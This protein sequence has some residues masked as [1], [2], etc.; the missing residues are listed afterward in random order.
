MKTNLK[1]VSFWYVRLPMGLAMFILMFIAVNPTV[2]DGC[3]W[4]G[5]HPINPADDKL[6]CRAYGGKVNGHWVGE[7]NV[8]GQIFIWESLM[9]SI[10]GRYTALTAEELGRPAIESWT[11]TIRTQW[12]DVVQRYHGNPV[13]I[14][15]DRTIRQ[16]DGSVIVA[17]IGE[18]DVEI[19]AR[20]ETAEW[21]ECD[22]DW[23]PWKR[24]RFVVPVPYT[25]ADDYRSE[26]GDGSFPYDLA[27]NYYEEYLA[28]KEAQEQAA[29]NAQTVQD[30][31][32]PDEFKPIDPDTGFPE[33]AQ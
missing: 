17:T 28:E 8:R 18:Y 22:S 20:N 2:A 24:W 25:M 27:D 14:S 26:Y 12:G 5:K 10:E 21:R 4:C 23:G 13:Y 30:V 3:D 29:T 11:V 7:D 16:S 15:W 33:G 1:V 31:N 6:V 19:L 9:F 32:D